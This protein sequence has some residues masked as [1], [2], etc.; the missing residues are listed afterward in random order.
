MQFGQF[1][2][3]IARNL[4]IVL[5]LVIGSNLAASSTPFDDAYKQG[6]ALL[7]NRKSVDVKADAQAALP[8]LTKAIKLQPRNAM[9]Y[10]Q[11]SRAFGALGQNKL[12]I[13]D[14]TRAIMLDPK[15]AIAYAN[16]GSAFVQLKMYPQAIEDFS[17][18]IELDPKD[19]ISYSNRGSAY[20]EMRYFEKSIADISKAISLAPADYVSYLNRGSSYFQAGNFKKAVADYSKSIEIHPTKFAYLMRAKAHAKLREDDLAAKDSGIALKMEGH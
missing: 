20:A 1:A 18:A 14:C 8:Y 16:R 17:K 12:V 15:C 9:A 7:D 19:V 5:L 11:R 4:T 3:R 6:T 10:A 2:S 13:D